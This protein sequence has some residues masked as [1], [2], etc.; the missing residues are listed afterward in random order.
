MG[1]L[2]VLARRFAAANLRA[3]VIGEPERRADVRRPGAIAPD[4]FQMTILGYGRE[5]YFRVSPGART[6]RVEVE[7]ID[8]EWRQLVLLVHE[9]A[10]SFVERLWKRNVQLDR[11]K[12]KVL[13]EDGSFVWIERRTDARKRH[14]LCGRDERQLFICQLPRPVTTVRDAHAALR[15]PALARAKGPAVRQGEWFFVP[16]SRNE[17]A[18]LQSA[19]RELRTVVRIRVPVGPGGHPHVADELVDVPATL[20][21]DVLV[22]RTLFARGRVRHQDHD[23]VRLPGW[24]K[25]V[26]NAEPVADDGLGRMDGVRWID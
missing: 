7:G 20:V 2:E 1:N 26:R 3:E 11:T 18:A 6:N 21:G 9:P 4:V 13:D 15:G 19:L 5:E 10:R 14:F 12:V 23:T 8:R 16:P 17:L 24:A 25:V 22:E